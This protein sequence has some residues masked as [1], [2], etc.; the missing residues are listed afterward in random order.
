MIQRVM[1]GAI[2]ANRLG[3]LLNHTWFNRLLVAGALALAAAVPLQLSTRLQM[4]LLAALVGAGGVLLLLQAPRLGL[5]GLVFVALT[6]PSPRLPG[7]LNV[8]VLLLGL[9]VGLW[10]FD[11]AVRRRQ[12]MLFA[13][14][15]TRPLLVMVAAAALAFVAGQLAW[16]PTAP[17]APLDS[18]LGGLAIYVLS[19]GAF[20]LT[21]HQFEDLRWLARL[22]W[23]FLAL[24]ALFIAGWLL[25]GVD[26][27]TRPLFQFGAT[28]NAMLWLWIVTLALSQALFN[29][30]L[31]RPA[32][33]ALLGL[34]L[35]T[36]FVAFVINGEWKSGYLP[37]FVAV[38]VL[39]ALRSP[40]AALL[41]ALVGPVLAL[42]ISSQAIASDEY[43]YSTRLDAWIIVLNMVRESPILGFGPANYYWYTP[44]FPIRGYAVQFNS[45]NQYIDI[46]AQTGLVG[47]A[48]F[49]WFMG[50]VA[51]VAW[52]LR[53]RA[54]LGFGRAYIHGALAGVAGMLA[55]GVLVDWIL[56][57]VYNI[58]LNGYRGSMLGWLFLGGVMSIERMV[59]R[60]AAATAGTGGET[61]RIDRTKER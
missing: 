34:T 29:E 51:L 47:L 60:Q 7:G 32:R 38:G 41:M 42:Y 14:P 54:P 20:L 44:L 21:A 59:Q 12:I 3:D 52:R 10:L 19:A 49:L 30:K 2:T 1:A 11:M 58:G 40:K 33:A 45:H 61:A 37:A 5:V 15:M 56:P 31:A 24:G 17:H 46:V 6:V 53:W 48:A 27:L 55:A 13:S 16:F 26:R 43:S 23:A 9:L 50:S 57:F 39:V 22:T 36:L 28:A 18:Q 4:L 25:P 35:A 8:A